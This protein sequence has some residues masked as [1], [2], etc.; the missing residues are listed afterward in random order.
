ML[1]RTRTGGQPL[2]INA[3]CREA[4]FEDETGRDRV[5]PITADASGGCS[6]AR[7][8]PLKR[9]NRALSPTPGRRRAGGRYR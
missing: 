5:R 8:A 6:A 1:I 3:L 2:L 4:C 9:W 7:D